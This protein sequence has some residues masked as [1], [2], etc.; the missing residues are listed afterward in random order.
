MAKIYTNEITGAC[1]ED[2]MGKEQVAWLSAEH[3]GSRAE[4][5]VPHNA[6]QQPMHRSARSAKARKGSPWHTLQEY[7]CPASTPEVSQA[8]W[9]HRFVH[10]GLL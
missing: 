10:H 8:A 1:K 7:C 3:I 5:P 9:R 2:A 4:L 6:V